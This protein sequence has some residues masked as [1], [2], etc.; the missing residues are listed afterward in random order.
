MWIRINVDPD[1]NAHPDPN[2]DP[3]ENPNADPDPDPGANFN[4]KP[5]GSGSGT[6]ALN[7]E[8]KIHVVDH[9]RIRISNVRT[10]PLSN[11]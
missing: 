6:T 4:A 7:R 2:A 9:V 3:G 5:C 11:L 1:P 10:Y 8:E